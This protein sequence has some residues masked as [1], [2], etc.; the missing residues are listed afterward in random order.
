MKVRSTEELIDVLANDLKARKR[1]IFNLKAA[2]ARARDHEKRWL[3]RAGYMLLYSH[4][5]GFVRTA[6]TAY[7]LFVRHQ[8]LSYSELSLNFVAAALKTKLEALG[9]VSK[10]SIVT[11]VTNELYQ[12]GNSAAEFHWAGELDCRSNLNSEVLVEITTLLGIT[13]SKYETKRHFL[14]ESLLFNRNGI[15]HG[16]MVEIDE[17]D[18]DAA[19]DLVIGIIEDFRSGI[20]NAAVTQAFRR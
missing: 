11:A 17:R 6:G 5:E 20:E 10:A 16:E 12:G 3:L 18:F 1:E 19:Y 13:F 9:Q 4:F 2:T 7:L 8:R 14:D 15:A